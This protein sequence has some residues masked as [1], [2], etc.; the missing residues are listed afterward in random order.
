MGLA[1]G[2]CTCFYRFKDFGIHPREYSFLKAMKY[3]KEC[4]IWVDLVFNLVQLIV[5][6]VVI[7]IIYFYSYGT[8]LIQIPPDA[9]SFTEIAK[10]TMAKVWG[11]FRDW[12]NSF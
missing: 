2:I 8:H 11:F 9:Y 6:V 4:P 7:D 3:K 5:L 12:Y 1:P 10:A